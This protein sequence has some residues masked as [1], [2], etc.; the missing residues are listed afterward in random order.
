[1]EPRYFFHEVIGLFMGMFYF[2]FTST[3][4]YKV[5][6]EDENDRKIFFEDYTK[7]RPHPGENSMYAFWHQDEL[8][9]IRYFAKTNIGVLISSSRDGTIMAKASDFLGYKTIRGSSTRRA[10]AGFL[11]AIKLVKE[12]YK[13]AMAVDGP[14]GP[15]YK[16][17]EGLPKL[18]EKTGR[19]IWPLR[20]YP[21]KC[22]TFEKAWNKIR[23]PYPFSTIIIKAGKRDLYKTSEALEAKLI[24]L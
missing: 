18:C 5:E 15:I 24:S 2:I 1:M 4:K 20:A 7:L 21:Q 8:A 16:V 19:P 22:Y 12:G 10:I 14:R 9:L 17:K 6:F 23:L 3:W 11:E 13:F